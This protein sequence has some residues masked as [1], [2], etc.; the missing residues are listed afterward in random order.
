[1]VPVHLLP[2]SQCLT[3][4]IWERHPLECSRAKLR[5]VPV[6]TAT[7]GPMGAC[8]YLLL[9][10]DMRDCP[11]TSRDFVGS[12]G[13]KL[14]NDTI[15][16]VAQLFAKVGGTWFPERAGVNG[17]PVLGRHRDLARLIL[18]EIERAE[19][20]SRETNRPID[21][22]ADSGSDPQVSTDAGDFSVGMT[23][24]YCPPADKRTIICRVEK[25]E[26]DRAYIVAVGREVGWVSTHTLLPLKS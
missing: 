22:A 15:E 20:A 7:I 26:N 10:S 12:G 13:L 5:I 24:E 18:A 21:P 4:P 6:R 14:S 25:I 11:T 19:A 9:T 2:Q 17:K 1:M 23:I 16:R 8:F 3:T